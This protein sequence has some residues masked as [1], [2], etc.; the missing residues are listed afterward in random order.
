MKPVLKKAKLKKLV[1]VTDAHLS[2]KDTKKVAGGEGLK[3]TTSTSL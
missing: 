1:V 2:P 3:G